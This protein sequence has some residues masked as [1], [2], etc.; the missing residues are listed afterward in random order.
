MRQLIQSPNYGR[1]FFRQ[2]NAGPP[3]NGFAGGVATCTSGVPVFRPHSDITQDCLDAMIVDLQHQSEMEQNFVEANVQGKL[4][5]MPAGEARFSAGVH[6]RTNSYRYI[7]DTL[8]T[9][10]S[11]L[12]L[13]LG[14]FPANSTRGKTEVSEVYGELLLPLLSGKT[15]VQH[16]NLE[17]GYR[18]SDYE[19][20]GGIDTYKALI[21]WGITDTL[22]FRGGRQQ[23]TRAPNIAEMFQAQSQ[24]W[25]AASPGDPCGLN[26]VAS[27]GANPAFN[28]NAAQVRALC[29]QLMSSGASVFYDPAT[30]QPPGASALWFVNAVGNPNVNP[31]DATTLTAGFVWQPRTGEPLR[32]GFS[33][34]IDWYEIEIDDMIAVEPGLRRVSSLLEPGEQPD[35][36]HQPRGVPAHH[37]QPVDGRCNGIECVLHQCRRCVAE[38]C[39]SL[40]DLASRSVGYGVRPSAGNVLGEFPRQHVARSH[41]ASD[42]HGAHHRLEGLARA[43]SGHV[44]EQRCVRLSH[45]HDVELRVQRLERE[46]ALAPFADGEVGAAGGAR[47][48]DGRYRDRARR[49]GVVRR[50]RRVGDVGSRREDRRCEWAWT[51]SSTRIP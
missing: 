11:Y 39:R 23:A 19:F 49:R 37:P 28:P 40:G 1:G 42:P 25:S 13:G 43:R 9:Q 45:V 10:A 14:T 6:S 18:Y 12:D 47:L 46:S 48:D 26:T 17:L 50:V 21:D 51:T 2:A 29:S 34:T 35:V 38:R 4:V 16:L 41:D 5:D 8:N 31:E 15:G 24:T 20:Q 7:F 3:G 32:D 27:Y 44:A 33:G 30:P 36:R 22:R